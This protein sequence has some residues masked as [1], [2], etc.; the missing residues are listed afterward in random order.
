MLK[1]EQISYKAGKHVILDQI[2][3]AFEVGKINM[4]IGPNGSGKSTLLKIL[5]AELKAQQGNVLYGDMSVSK[6]SFKEL[7][8]IRSVLSQNSDL[9][10]PLTVREVVM[11]GRYPHFNLQAN[12]KDLHFCHEVMEYLH[13]SALADRNFLTLSGGE[14]Q[15]VHFARVLTQ[16]WE[17][18]K[19]GIRYLFLDE[20]LNS[21]DI[22]Y[23]HEFLKI[24][25]EFTTKNTLVIAVIH[26]INLAIQYGH[27][28][29]ALKGG[30]K[31]AEGNPDQIITPPLIEEIY[32]I[33]GEMIFHERK[34]MYYFVAD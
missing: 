18:P 7:A 15:R 34:K 27:F 10:F 5:A 24:T 33:K 6:L 13:I 14:K 11:M 30:R 23:Q 16:I 2:S 25:K 28:V 17:E 12:R 20:P 32:G 26:D 19:E 29:I 1:F 22:N 8:K 3:A 21:L 9:S 31:M 4:I